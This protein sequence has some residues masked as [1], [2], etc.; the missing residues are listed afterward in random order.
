MSTLLRG[1]VA[2][3][4]SVNI[5][6]LRYYEKRGLMPRP[7]RS[8][9]NYRLY[10]EYTVKRIRFVKRAQDLGFS[11]KEIKELLSL[12]AAPRARCADVCGRSKEKIQ[13]IDEKIRSL[14]A[15]RRALSK[16]VAECSRRGKASDCHILSV[17]DSEL[18]A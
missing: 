12:R 6:T 15:M 2:K 11:L 1:D 18:E 13:E 7:A 5:E 16:L 3:Q 10:S 4:A 17:L 8:L 14:K 9:S